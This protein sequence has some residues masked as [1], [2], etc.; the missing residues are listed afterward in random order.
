[1]TTKLTLTIQQDVIKT[2][3]SYAKSNGR[4]LSEL[5]ENYLKTLSDKDKSKES[6]S[7]RVK[8][9]VGSISLPENVD[10]RSVLEDEINKKHG[11]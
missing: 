6:L 1:M 5:I 11:I 10:Y 2:A 3:K 9:L 8:R 7:P 4:S